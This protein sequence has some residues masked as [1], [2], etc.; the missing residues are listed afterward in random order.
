[1]GV[2]GLGLVCSGFR[3]SGLKGCGISWVCCISVL[4]VKDC[5][6]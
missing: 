3:V 1:M 2:S 5:R 4:Q 6:V